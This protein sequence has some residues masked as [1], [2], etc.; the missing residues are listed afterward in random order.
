MILAL[1]CLA[2]ANVLGRKLF[3]LPVPG[4]IDWVEQFMAVFVFAGLA[5]CQREGGHVRME[6]VIGRFRGR[7]LWTLE[8]LSILFMLLLTT[9]LIIGTWSHFGRSFDFGSSL[10][11]RDSS[12]DLALPR[13]P[14][15]LL[16]PIALG[17]LWVRLVLQLWGF[18][19][20]MRLN[21][22][23][24]VAVPLMRDPAARAAHEADTVR[25]AD[26]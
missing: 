25:G 5:Y 1:V 3:N 8:F 11:S 18:G 24:P 17:L 7:M 10:W 4:F 16:V 26:G 2:A 23:A 20:A 22:E 12:I 9:V 13:W 6:I 19:R 21:P 15:K 14:S